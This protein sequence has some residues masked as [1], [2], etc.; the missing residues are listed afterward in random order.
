MGERPFTPRRIAGWSLRTQ[1]AAII[2][3][4]ALPLFIGMGAALWS[5]ANAALEA[6][7]RAILF[8]ATSLAAAVDAELSKHAVLGRTLSRSPALVSGDLEAFDVE[9]RRA[10][11][12]NAH[13]WVIVATSDGRQI[14]NLARPRGTPLPVRTQT[15]I[16]AQQESYRTGQPVISGILVGPVTG[17]PGFSIDFPIKVDGVYV[18]S[19][20]MS[21]KATEIL[22]LLSAPEVPPNWLIGVIDRNGRFVARVPDHAA[23]V[24]ELASQGWRRT[25]DI[26][27]VHEFRSLEGDNLVQA[28]VLAAAAGWSVGVAV[29]KSELHAAVWR[30]L[31]WALVVAG[32]ISAW[33]I[34]L[35]VILARRL[36]KAI[37]DVSSDAARMVKGEDLSREPDLPE[38]KGLWRD[39]KSALAARNDA[40]QRLRLVM[41][42]VNHRS[43]NLLTVIQSIARQTIAT[44]PSDFLRRFADRLEGLAA[45][46]D[47]LVRNE[48]KGVELEDLVRSQLAPYKSLIDRRVTIEGPPL[49]VTTAAAQTIGMALHE[50]ATNAA[51]YGALSNDVGRVGIVWA[52]DPAAATFTMSWAET[53]GPPPAPSSSKGF[54]ST[55][56]GAM[57]QLGLRAEVEADFRREGLVWTV[58]CPAENLLDCGKRA[59]A[60]AA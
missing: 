12:G 57:V 52:V 28:N 55:V 44:S 45:S 42:E 58:R 29:K 31:L 34:A 11:E 51:K 17:D 18:R 53:G 23:R 25:R 27:G 20:V 37:D 56:T 19:L 13:S 26:E 36:T 33:S 60:E 7:Q 49:R 40:D 8:T 48:W 35:A 59:A 16:A 38:L 5:L 1:L 2:L 50:L 24:G 9:A 46:Q 43:K 41:R 3:V 47:L 54:G 22:K 32:L 14:L 4:V 15:G 39:L 30:S 10:F 6:Q 21:I